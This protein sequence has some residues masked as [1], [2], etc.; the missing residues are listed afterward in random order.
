MFNVTSFNLKILHKYRIKLNGI[1]VTIWENTLNFNSWTV[2][3]VF[4]N[5]YSSNNSS[6]KS[7]R[8]D[9]GDDNWTNFKTSTIRL[10]LHK[11]VRC[12]AH[13][14][15]VIGICIHSHKTKFKLHPYEIMVLH[16]QQEFNSA[17]SQCK[18][19]TIQLQ[20]TAAVYNWW[21]MFYLMNYV[22]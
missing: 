12:F 18:M 22:R 7:F 14:T 15:H 16:G 19:Y 2:W 17:T 1:M 6:D 11:S 21:G 13:E 3:R 20:P 4:W 5:S 9:K 8:S 10:C